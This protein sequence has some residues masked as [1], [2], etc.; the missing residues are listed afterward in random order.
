MKRSSQNKRFQAII[1]VVTLF[2]MLG[3][4]IPINSQT[5]QAIKIMGPEGDIFLLKELGAVITEADEKIK[6]EMVLPPDQRDEKYKDVDIRTGDFIKM[7]NGK[8]IKSVK[9]LEKVFNNL[10]IGAEVKF[11]IRR[12]REML[13]EKFIK[14]DPDKLPG[15]MMMMTVSEEDGGVASALLDVGLILKQE[16]GK[17][18]V[19]EVIPEMAEVFGDNV[20][21]KGD[22]I[23]AIQGKALTGPEQLRKKCGESKSGE[24]VVLT[25]AR[26]SKEFTAEFVK[27]SSCSVQKKII[28]K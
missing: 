21:Q 14:A 24:T 15:K 19:D 16:D 13:I 17:I 12:D 22:I 5:K 18:V 1:G 6:V 27:E 7:F 25:L 9:Q 26:D 20:P 23:T 28:K 8:S 2:F 3:I 10:D 4:C 11:G